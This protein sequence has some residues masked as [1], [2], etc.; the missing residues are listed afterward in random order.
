MENK[1]TMKEFEEMFVE[2]QKVTMNELEKDFKK[3]NKECG[4]EDNTFVVCNI[5]M[6]MVSLSTLHKNLFKKEEPSK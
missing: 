6:S 5:M 3:V 1:Y 4:D 2:A